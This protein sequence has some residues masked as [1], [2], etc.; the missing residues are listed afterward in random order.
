MSQVLHFL[1]K[2]R[3]DIL[4]IAD[5]RLAKEIENNVKAEWGG[6]AFFSSF[7]SQSRGVATFMQKN[8]PVKI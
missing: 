8:L 7:D 6:H 2:K 5:T 4:I 3:P 1:K